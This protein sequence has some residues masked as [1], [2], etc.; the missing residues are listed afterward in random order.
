ME[1]AFQ[2]RKIKSC[3]F[4]RS[5]VR[6]KVSKLINVFKNGMFCYH[7]VS[8]ALSLP[9]NY[10]SIPQFIDK[11]YWCKEWKNL[12]FWIGKFAKIMHLKICWMN[13]NEKE[14]VSTRKSGY[15]KQ[16]LPIHWLISVVKIQIL[17][18]FYNAF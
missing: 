2:R 17:N 16:V 5:L 13:F 9:A 18:A 3:T 15:L 8:A 4:C 10:I 11:T 1:F 14:L 7:K 6:Y 12:D